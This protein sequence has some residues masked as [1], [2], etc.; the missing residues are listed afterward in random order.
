M[1]TKR[2]NSSIVLCFQVIYS[3]VHRSQELKSERAIIFIKVLGQISL[4]HAID[5]LDETS[6]VGNFGKS[7][8][9]KNV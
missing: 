4:H 1:R 7:K 6:A 9:Q 8:E 2:N 3:L 5:V